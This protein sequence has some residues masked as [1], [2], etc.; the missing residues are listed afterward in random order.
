[1]ALY[2]THFSSYLDLVGNIESIVVTPI[3]EDDTVQGSSKP[4]GRRCRAPGPR[5]VEVGRGV[6]DPGI[7]SQ[8]NKPGEDNEEEGTNLDN[9][10]GVGEPICVLRVEHQGCQRQHSYFKNQSAGLTQGSKSVA[11]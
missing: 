1:M 4:V 8:N 2:I 5:I 9:P 10:N 7:T 11:C 6:L 3:R